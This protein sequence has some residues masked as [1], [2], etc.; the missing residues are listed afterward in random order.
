MIELRYGGD[1][2]AELAA[3]LLSA[4]LC[5]DPDALREVCNVTPGAWPDRQFAA[6]AD[7]AAEM[8]PGDR[9]AEVAIDK[10]IDLSVFLGEVKAHD[11]TCSPERCRKWLNRHHAR[12]ELARRVKTLACGMDRMTNEQITDR[13]Q[14]ILS[15]AVEPDALVPS[16]VVNAPEPPAPVLSAGPFPGTMSLLV[17]ES[18]RGKSWVAL[19]FAVSVATGEAVLKS[20]QPQAAA[21]V[22]FISYEDAAGVVRDRIERLTREARSPSAWSAIRDGRL[23]FV[24]EPDVALFAQAARNEP[25]TATNL[26]R[27]LERTIEQVK[28]ALVVIDPASGAFGLAD[29]NDN[30]AMNIIAQRLTALAAKHTVA[31]LVVH[32]TGKAL[33][34]TATQHAARGASALTSRARWVG[35]L[36]K[37]GA[38][39]LKLAVVKCSYAR[40]PAGP[41]LLRQSESGPVVEIKPEVRDPRVLMGDVVGWI[42]EHSDAC[43]ALRGISRGKGDARAL[44]DAV[45]LAHPWATCKHVETAAQLALDEGKLTEVEER[46]ANRHRRPVLR[47]AKD[48][49]GAALVDFPKKSN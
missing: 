21:P 14:D 46:D 30:A 18:G 11:A 22:V 26:F 16:D 12:R 13:L 36:L 2:P 29:E 48:S 8:A 24:C 47:P 34:D 25:P 38:D 15:D 31:L 37:D 32:H 19:A 43:V 6:V 45:A 40:T 23:Q 44:T 5:G 10:D 27:R 9:L 3:A 1:A 41:V 17:G 7:V 28:P 49:A 33:A 39:G 42:G 4:A 35:Q 20:F